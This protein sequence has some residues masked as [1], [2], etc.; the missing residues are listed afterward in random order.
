M[1]E[2]DSKVEVMIEGMF[3]GYKHDLMTSKRVQKGVNRHFDKP[4]HITSGS[5]AVLLKHPFLKMLIT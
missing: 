5:T 3:I 2:Y 1:I 4:L